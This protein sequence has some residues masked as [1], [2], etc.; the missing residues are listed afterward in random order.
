MYV[1]SLKFK[2]HSGLGTCCWENEKAMSNYYKFHLVSQGLKCTNWACTDC[3][4]TKKFQP[5]PV[6]SSFFL[7]PLHPSRSQSKVAYQPTVDFGEI[8][9]FLER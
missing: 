2:E 4:L 8:A 7:I 5:I 9:S 1:R 3:S 6:L